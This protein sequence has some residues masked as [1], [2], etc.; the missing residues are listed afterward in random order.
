MRSSIEL[1]Q[2]V[3][4]PAESPTGL[5]ELVATVRVA[6]L[7]VWELARLSVARTGSCAGE[8]RASIARSVRPSW[9][10]NAP[11]TDWL[12]LRWCSRWAPNLPWNRLPRARLASSNQ[13]TTFRLSRFELLPVSFRLEFLFLPLR[14]LWARR[15]LLR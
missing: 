4:S 11:R 5:T 14:P 12:L 10:A 13:P 7:A 2:G 8:F 15:R 3:D 6:G 9:P 1:G